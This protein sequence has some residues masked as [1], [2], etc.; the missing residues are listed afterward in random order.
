VVGT[1]ILEY[2]IA[3]PIAMLLNR[4]TAING[5]LSG[6]ILLPWVTPSIVIAYVWMFLF[7]SNFGTVHYFLQSIGLVGQRSLLSDPALV[8]PALIIVSAWKGIPFMT[9]GLLAA[10]KTIPPDLYE[11]ASVDG[12]SAWQRFVFITLPLLRRVSVVLILVLGILAFYSF[13]LVWVITKGGPGS[14]STLIGVYLF[15]NFFERQEF[16]YAGT[17]GVLMLILLISFSAIYLRVLGRQK[18]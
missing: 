18:Y 12:A 17:M 10:L 5:V 7:N 16:S 9:I 14:S 11:A 15:R 3:L 2:V 1:V 4:R 8:M 13:D 6:L